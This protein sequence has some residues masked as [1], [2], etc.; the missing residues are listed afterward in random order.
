MESVTAF[1][2]HSLPPGYKDDV[3]AIRVSQPGAPDALQLAEVDVPKPKRGEVVVRIEAIGVN[4]IDVYHRTGLYKLDVPFTPGSEAAGRV[5]VVGEGVE[6]FRKGDRVAYA[7]VA[8]SYAEYAAVP[9]EKLVPV[10]E[11]IDSRIAAAA[12]LQGMTAHYLALST[13]PLKQGDTALVHAAAGGAGG[14]LVQIAKLRG[15]RVFGTV[16]TDVKANIAS[17]AGCDETILYTSQDFEEEVM[18]HT[19]GKGVNVVYD[20]VGRTTF[21]K[22]LNSLAVRGLLA[23]FGQSSGT[24][25][26][27]D[28]ARLAKKGIYLTRPSLAQYT[29]NREELLWRAHDLF[30]WIQSGRVRVRI[31]RELPLAKAAE[32]HRLLESWQTTGKILLIP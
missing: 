6:G 14:L 13:Y 23:L 5:E 22:S 32:A 17:D 31:D 18:R 19:G 20:S 3:K 12:M 2:G 25:A 27:V 7:M 26:P 1:P 11:A 9:A 30:D 15:A 24:V 16:S 21:D 28:P 8:G 4:F 29:A 10:P